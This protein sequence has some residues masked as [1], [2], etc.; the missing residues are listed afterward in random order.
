MKEENKIKEKEMIQKPEKIGTFPK[1]NAIYD[2]YRFQLDMLKKYKERK[3]E[4]RIQQYESQLIL[5]EGRLR[6][7]C[8]KNNIQIS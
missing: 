4:K 8:K 6:E 2:D 1:G 7:F 3:N 5:A